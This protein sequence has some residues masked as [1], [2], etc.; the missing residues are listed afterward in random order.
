MH[1]D[2]MRRPLACLHDQPADGRNKK[3]EYTSPVEYGSF[4]DPEGEIESPKD[5]TRAR[6]TVIHV[7]RLVR[8]VGVSEVFRYGMSPSLP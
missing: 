5:I 4:A 3:S 7:R 6:G 1:A 8:L 2:P